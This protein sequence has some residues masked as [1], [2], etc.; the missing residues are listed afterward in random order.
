MFV[1][2]CIAPPVGIAFFSAAL[3]MVLL[4][5]VFEDPDAHPQNRAHLPNVQSVC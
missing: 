1:F 5:I 2:L 4:D 3:L